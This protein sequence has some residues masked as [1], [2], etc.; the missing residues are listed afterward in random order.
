MT[1]VSPTRFISPHRRFGTHLPNEA[2]F[3]HLLAILPVEHPL[4]GLE[5]L[6]EAAQVI[7]TLRQQSSLIALRAAFV[8]LLVQNLPY[9]MCE[10]IADDEEANATFSAATVD[11]T[12]A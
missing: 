11:D 8:I 6:G 12:P 7:Q 3:H 9:R 1:S 4:V 2:A 5:R 10:S